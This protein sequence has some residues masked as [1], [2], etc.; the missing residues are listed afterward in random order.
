MVSIFYASPSNSK[1]QKIFDIQFLNS[2]S[3]RVTIYVLSNTFII[4]Q[5]NPLH[6]NYAYD[7]LA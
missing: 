2:G 5:E 6:N 3:F 7:H 1:S 4:P